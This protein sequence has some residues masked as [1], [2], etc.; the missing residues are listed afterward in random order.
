MRSTGTAVMV[1]MGKKEGM[2][3]CFGWPTTSL[4]PRDLRLGVESKRKDSDVHDT[5]FPHPT[6]LHSSLYSQGNLLFLTSS[7]QFNLSFSFFFFLFSQYQNFSNIF[8]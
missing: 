8:A 4:L 6:L 7:Y 1:R 3:F 5:P 2:G